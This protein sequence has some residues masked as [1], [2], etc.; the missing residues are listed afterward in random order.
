MHPEM[1]PE[2]RPENT[3]IFWGQLQ[4]DL[5]HTGAQFFWDIFGDIFGYVPKRVFLHAS[6]YF[7]G[8]V[9]KI[10]VTFLGDT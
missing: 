2:M 1:C 7:L 6:N 10:W 9:I 8:K 4:E 5:L 3:Q